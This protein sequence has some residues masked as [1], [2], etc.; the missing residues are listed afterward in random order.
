MRATAASDDQ[1]R[2]VHRD[3]ASKVARH[4]ERIH[5]AARATASRNW[6]ARAASADKAG[7]RAVLSLRHD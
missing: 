5:I 6:Q 1:L 2:L 3:N 4:I 7:R